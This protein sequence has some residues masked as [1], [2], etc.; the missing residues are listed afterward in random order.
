[1]TGQEKYDRWDLA[2]LLYSLTGSALSLAG[3]ISVAVV[4]AI[5]Y[6]S[7]DV[8]G[9]QAA[10]WT[11][12]GLLTLSAAGVPALWLSAQIVI[13]RERPASRIPSAE[14]LRVGGLF[15]IGLLLGF[16]AYERGILPPLLGPLAQILA[17]GAPAIIAILL[18]RR[19]GPVVPLRRIWGHI[20]VGMWAVPVFALIVE[21]LAFLL[22]ILTTSAG[23]TLAPGGGQ[24]L[25]DL[26]Q[27]INSIDTQPSLEAVAEIALHPI[28]I[29]LIV[30]FLG[31]LVPLIE[32]L[33]KTATVWPLLPRRISGEEAFLGGALGGTG[34][35][36]SEA[37]FLAQPG[38]GWVIT[39]F[40]RAGATMM[41]ALATGIASWALAEALIRRRWVQGTVGLGLAI[42]LHGLW[43]V[44]A[45]GI[46]FTQLAASASIELPSPFLDTISSASV[47][48]IIVLGLGA[49]WLLPRLQRRAGSPR[50]SPPDRDALERHE[51]PL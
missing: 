10:Q 3:G 44:S 41:H 31:I 43:N 20:L 22:G 12:T 35:A 9:A 45:I 26:Q 42:F 33:A 15:P 36:L 7:A 47:A 30:M 24:L 17:I 25:R 50:S 51:S 8:E 23:L 37:L 49:T 39:A 19:A 6:L 48:T 38:A 27:L 14:W 21:G 28:V 46:G 11:A 4:A 5:A 34:F 40:A 29:L 18:V 13:N 2:L 32:E 16:V 1:M